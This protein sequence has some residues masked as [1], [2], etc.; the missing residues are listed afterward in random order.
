MSVIRWMDVSGDC[1]DWVS[2]TSGLFFCTKTLGDSREDGPIQLR[3]P[4]MT[5]FKAD[6]GS[7]VL[8][9]LAHRLRR[10][11][12]SKTILDPMSSASWV[13]AWKLQRKPFGG[14]GRSGFWEGEIE[15][16]RERPEKNGKHFDL[17]DVIISP[18]E[19]FIQRWHNADHQHSPGA[20][21]GKQ[22]KPGQNS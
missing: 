1:R 3:I 15:I 13:G 16:W 12:N 14:F 2:W 20:L 8:L 6:L 5:S 17:T 9:L 10:W 4:E 7:N 21:A 22:L 19:T 18:P 11:A